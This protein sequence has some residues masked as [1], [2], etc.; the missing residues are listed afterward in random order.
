MTK[1]ASLINYR[2]NSFSVKKA[3]PLIVNLGALYRGNL[4]GANIGW[5]EPGLFN[6][7]IGTK[8]VDLNIYIFNKLDTLPRNFSIR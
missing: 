1:D 8:S 5:V 2:I 3:H 4:I 6:I 7:F